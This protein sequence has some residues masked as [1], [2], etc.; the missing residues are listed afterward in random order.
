MAV[1]KLYV[2]QSENLFS[3]PITSVKF[4]ILDLGFWIGGIAALYP[5]IKQTEFLKSAIRNPQSEI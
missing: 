3:L 4:W 5:F 2:S 1:K